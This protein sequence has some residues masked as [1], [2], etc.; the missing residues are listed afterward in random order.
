[1]RRCL[2]YRFAMLLVFLPVHA[3]GQQGGSHHHHHR[4]EMQVI[5]SGVVMNENRSRLPRGC[6]EIA[7][8]HAVTVHAGRQFA[9]DQPGV[10]FGMSAYEIR[11]EPCSRVE[12][13]FVNEDEVRHQWMVHGLP[14]YLYPTG[15]FHI[16][17]A[18]G[19]T[20]TGSFIVPGE[21]Q[22]YLIHCDMAQ[23]MEK[24]MRGQLIVGDGSGDLWGV[25]GISDPF[26]RAS[27]LPEMAPMWLILVGL[28]AFFFTLRAVRAD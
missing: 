22:T 2:R 21:D 20:M 26:Y 3:L 6:P 7:R 17:A 28:A 12:L 18:G 10:I 8:D 25:P 9:K 5:S 14:N 24:G 1:M 13:T 19:E 11:V 4:H 15:M 16:E 23:H 27:Y